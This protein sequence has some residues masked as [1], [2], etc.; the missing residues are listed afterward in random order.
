MNDV[1]KDI[2][3]AAL[4]LPAPARAMLAEDLLASLESSP[5]EIKE[6]WR[7]EIERRVKEIREGKVELIPGDQVMQELRAQLKR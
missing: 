6:A 1:Y 3:N 2:A 5:E 4:A 7:I